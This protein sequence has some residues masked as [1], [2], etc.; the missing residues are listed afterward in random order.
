M[1]DGWLASAIA[2]FLKVPAEPE[3]PA[4]SPGSVRIFNAGRGYYRYRVVKWLVRQLGAG[5]GIVFGVLFVMTDFDFG[6]VPFGR[7]A[8]Q[9]IEAFA[10]AGYLVQLPFSFLLVG[11][12]YRYRWY[13]TTDASLRIRE[14][15]T[16]VRERTMTFANIQNL[17]LRQGPLQRLFGIS[18]LQVRT[19]GGGGS[20]SSDESG[21]GHSEADNMHLGYFRGVDDAEAIRDLILERMRRLRDSGLGD[22]DEPVE[23]G[24]PPIP[25]EP[26]R[27]VHDAAAELLAEARRLRAA[28]GA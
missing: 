28:L 14:G 20:E 16:T 1:T 17:A 26:D 7:E 23:A 13:M 4:G 2:R 15:V 25:S 24:E 22:P 12:D 3:P 10:I 5:A 9:V 8:W 18:D 6:G 27:T 19:A 11:L 21:K